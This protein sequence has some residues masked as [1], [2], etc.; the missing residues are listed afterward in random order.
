MCLLL[1]RARQRHADNG[2]PIEAFRWPCRH[3]SFQVPCTV[4]LPSIRL[5]M[6]LGLPS[7]NS[8]FIAK[9]LERQHAHAVR[10]AVGKFAFV[11]ADRPILHAFAGL[12]AVVPLAFVGLD[13]LIV[14][15][16]LHL[17]GAVGITLAAPA[18]PSHRLVQLWIGVPDLAPG[19]VS[20]IHSPACATA[21]RAARNPPTTQPR[22]SRGR[23]SVRIASLPAVAPISAPTFAQCGNSGTT[24][25]LSNSSRTSIMRSR[26]LPS[27]SMIQVIG[28][29]SGSPKPLTVMSFS[30]ATG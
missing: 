14:L 17:A 9:F 27:V 2:T 18:R 29:P 30:T 15:E 23:I 26:T 1:P 11:A 8:T 19:I 25:P 21:S 22:Q 4:S 16:P 13:Q 7:R 28:T 12:P 10:Q 3:P 20:A 6:P 24:S 5:P